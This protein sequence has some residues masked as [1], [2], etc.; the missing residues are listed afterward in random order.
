MTNVEMRNALTALRE[1]YPKVLG[2]LTTIL[3]R[4]IDVD[5]P[6][7]S[8]MRRFLKNH[9]GWVEFH[10]RLRCVDK[11]KNDTALAEIAAPDVI[12]LTG[13]DDVMTP[14]PRKK[15]RKLSDAELERR[16]ILTQFA[17]DRAY[18][19]AQ[20]TVN[21]ALFGPR[22][23]VDQRSGVIFFSG[24]GNRQG[25]NFPCALIKNA[26]G[27]HGTSILENLRKHGAFGQRT[28]PAR[29]AA[30]MSGVARIHREQ[31]EENMYD[32]VFTSRPYNRSPAVGVENKTKPQLFDGPMDVVKDACKGDFIALPALTEMRENF[33]HGQVL[34]HL[35]KLNGVFKSH[36]DM[37]SAGVVLSSV[38]NTVK[39]SVCFSSE[40]QRH[41]RIGKNHCPH[42]KVFDFESGDVLVFNGDVQAACC[43]GVVEVTDNVVPGACLPAWLKN[44]R[45][46]AQWRGR[47][48]ERLQ[49]RQRRPGTVI[50]SGRR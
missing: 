16:Q 33:S 5:V 34:L 3:R 19:A 8:Q 39:F 49:E 9:G 21:I 22:V 23:G 36:L 47:I 11:A 1:R 38:G 17:D 37:N 43:H 27:C 45:L 46:S 48:D 10:G 12:D 14:G 41:S 26:D 6:G 18:R 2:E 25:T 29:M 15:K 20:R 42:C 28:V 13:D 35:F 50:N 30:C 31:I 7:T 24:P 4:K 40:C 44:K 32:Q